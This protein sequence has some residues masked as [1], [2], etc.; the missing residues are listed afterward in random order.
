VLEA[1]AS[2]DRW[3]WHF[4]FGL[5]GALHD[6]NVLHRSHLLS[7]LAKG[8]ALACNYTINDHDYTMKYYLA[9]GI[10]PE[11]TTFVNTIGNPESRA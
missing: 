2:E 1:V 4:V 6:I 3:I 9:D 10:Y 5:P 8:D 7:W 11:W